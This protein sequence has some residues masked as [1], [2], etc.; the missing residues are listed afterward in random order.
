[1]PI[2]IS[3]FSNPEMFVNPEVI[4]TKSGDQR[5]I[6][7]LSGIVHLNLKGNSTENWLRDR[8]S[9]AIDIRSVLPENI[10]FRIE[11]QTSIVTVNSI[12]NAGHS[13]NAGYAVDSCGVDRT[14]RFNHLV[15][16]QGAV[17]IRDVD[18]FLYRIG[19]YSTLLGTFGPLYVPII[20]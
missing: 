17:A 15:S 9:L 5:D 2:Y 8:F 10:G 11:Q 6:I 18:A 14:G 16:I 1:M 12:F 19:Y 4:H 7:V 13:V 3:Q 20:D